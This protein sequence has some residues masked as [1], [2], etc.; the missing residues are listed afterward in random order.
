[1]LT[2][3]PIGQASPKTW[4]EPLEFLKYL[5]YFPS[6]KYFRF[7]GRHLGFSDMRQCHYISQLTPLGLFF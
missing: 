5:N 2:I 7:F 1:M 6:Y 4:V 3:V